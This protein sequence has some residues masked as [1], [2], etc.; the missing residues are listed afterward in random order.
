MI[1]LNIDVTSIAN[2]MVRTLSDFRITIFL[3]EYFQRIFQDCI[4]RLLYYVENCGS[5]KSRDA[6]T[7]S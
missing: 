2:Y 5:E 1:A 7:E 4:N 3:L 6:E